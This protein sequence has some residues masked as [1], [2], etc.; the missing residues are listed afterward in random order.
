MTNDEKKEKFSSYIHMEILRLIGY[1]QSRYRV[2]T[3]IEIICSFLF[4]NK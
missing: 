3:Y 1:E 4:I 2:D